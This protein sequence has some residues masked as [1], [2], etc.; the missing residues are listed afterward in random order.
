MLMHGHVRTYTYFVCFSLARI[1]VHVV[2]GVKRFSAKNS[3]QQL[4]AIV[5]LTS[6]LMDFDLDDKSRAL[7]IEPS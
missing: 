3:P 1:G 6:L 4:V 2:K 7:S 5:L